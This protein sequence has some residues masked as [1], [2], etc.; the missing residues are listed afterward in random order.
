MSCLSRDLIVRSEALSF[1]P[2]FTFTN[3]TAKMTPWQ[4]GWNRNGIYYRFEI[5]HSP[6]KNIILSVIS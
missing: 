4:K 3:T 2:L 1:F 6:K 5:S